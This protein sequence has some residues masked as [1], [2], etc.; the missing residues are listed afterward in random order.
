MAITSRS[1]TPSS[2]ACLRYIPFTL[3]VYLHEYIG[4]LYTE[5]FVAMPSNGDAEQCTMFSTELTAIPRCV[6][7]HT[8]ELT[9]TDAARFCEIKTFDMSTC[10]LYVVKKNKAMRYD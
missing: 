1:S 2:S 6:Q 8:V 9:G 4:F 7:G 5:R 10:R 3:D